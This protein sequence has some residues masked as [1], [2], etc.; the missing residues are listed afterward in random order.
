MVSGGIVLCF[1]ILCFLKYPFFAEVTV[2]DYQGIILPIVL[3]LSYLLQKVLGV[4]LSRRVFI[5]ILFLWL[6]IQSRVFIMREV[7]FFKGRILISELAGDSEGY[8]G[9]SIAS[10]LRLIG[11]TYHL[12]GPALIPLKLD[13]NDVQRWFGSQAR[14]SLVITGSKKSLRV[15]LPLVQA[16]SHILSVNRSFYRSPGAK[17]WVD[18]ENMS[19][20]L[21]SYDRPFLLPLPPETLVLNDEIPKV[22]HHYVGW[23]SAYFNP[24]YISNGSVRLDTIHE[25]AKI[26]A[27]WKHP[28]PRALA[29][30]LKSVEELLEIYPDFPKSQVRLIQVRLRKIIKTL[31]PGDLYVSVQNLRALLFVSQGDLR[32][33]RKIYLSLAKDSRFTEKQRNIAVRNL[34]NLY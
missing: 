2:E 11:R 25:V 21:F 28:E 7:G 31:A 29:R 22:V 24:E 15:H 18:R 6:G 8:L 5:F 4:N 9:R 13:G 30:Y 33:A 17:F 14:P 20:K 1:L 19:V 12:A 32:R 27:P 26:D 10:G 3:V 16:Y 34:S 23:L